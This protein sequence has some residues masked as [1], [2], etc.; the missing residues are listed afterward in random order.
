MKQEMEAERYLQ[1]EFGTTE[2]VMTVRQINRNRKSTRQQNHRVQNVM[3]EKKKAREKY[4]ET[5][6]AEDQ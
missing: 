2:M 3:K 1:Q 5:E 4:A 6:I